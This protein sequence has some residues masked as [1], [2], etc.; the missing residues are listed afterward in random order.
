MLGSRT[1]VLLRCSLVVVAA[2][3]GPTS[4]SGPARPATSPAAP[5]AS[6][7]P[8]GLDGISEP[9]LRAHVERLASD[10][11][12]GRET[13]RPGARLAAEYLAERFAGY[14]LRPLPGK[15]GFT[16]DYTLYEQGFDEHRTTVAI[17]AGGATRALA[18]GADFAPFDFSDAGSAEADVVFAGYGITAPEI[19]HD[20]YEGLDV[21]GK[22]VLVL[23][24][25]PREKD[26]ASPF[27]KHPQHGLFAAKAMNAARRGALGMLLVTDP[28]NHEGGDDLRMSGRLRLEPPG[29]D[30]TAA[31]PGAGRERGAARR[32]VAAGAPR[33]R[34]RDQRGAR[35]RDAA[36]R[37][38]GRAAADEPSGPFLAVHISQEVAGALVAPTG[39]TLR[40]LQQAL[41]GGARP[42]AT[43]LTGVRA[44]VSITPRAQPR[45]VV[46]Q[47][48]VGFIEG[49]DP[50]LRDQWIVI[51]AHYDHLGGYPSG[52]DADTIY[53]GAD[54]NASGT[55]ALLE[56][57]Q[58]FATAP[59]RP[60]RSLAFMAFS[61]EEKGLLGSRAMVERE[62]FPVGNVTVMVNLDMIGR[63]G[64]EPVSIGG[65]GYGTQLR[66]LVEAANGDG[67]LRLAFDGI[68][69]SGNSDH[70]PFYARG[71]PFL[72]FFTGLHDDY[73]QL[74]D[75]A[76]KVEYARMTEI[77]RLVYRTAARLAAGDVT[78]RFIHHITWLGIQV[79][80]LDDGVGGARRAVI[81]AV[82]PGSRAARAGLAAGDVIA[83]FGDTPLADAVRVGDGFRAIE[84]GTKAR[85]ATLRAGEPRA[86]EVERARHGYLGVVTAPVADEQRKQLGLTDDEGVVIGDLAEDG[87]AGA[88][89]IRKGDVL[90]R[91]AGVPVGL[92]TLSRQLA[93]IGAG[94]KITVTVVRDG[95]RKDL[96]LTLAA[97]P[98]QRA[99]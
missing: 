5:I 99:P 79:E 54:D 34:A 43:A 94:E 41:D 61:G 73:H 10:E 7:P 31:T 9:E 98:E 29:A 36:T 22:L 56:L 71:I 27:A 46:A 89:G 13:L 14:G 16:L 1:R 95:E 67:K 81:T 68:D 84:P 60:R 58:A 49:T 35:A 70:H 53:N 8:A 51:G 52:G 24:H 93:Q 55:A 26:E 90:I 63:N 38:R 87:P 6:A 45:E 44:A 86:V 42:R 65:D 50:A 40:D 97:R 47:N 18:P 2:A 92:R 3:C 25:A 77:V 75:H 78:P 72:F 4:G 37:R 88:A 76:D 62:L 39:A 96:S 74:S 12:A 69:Y 21:R 48:V 66:E 59:E 83:G 15:P 17:T 20:D 64:E 19:G 82:T 28:L 32:R 33:D 80:V 30:A 57:A 11:L 85:L 23:R 91:I